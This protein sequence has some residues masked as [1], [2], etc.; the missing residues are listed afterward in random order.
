V[1]QTIPRSA[2]H[3]ARAAAYQAWPRLALP[4]VGCRSPLLALLKSGAMSRQNARN[5]AIVRV[6]GAIVLPVALSGANRAAAS[7]LTLAG[8]LRL[9]I[10]SPRGTIRAGRYSA[11]KRGVI[12]PSMV[13]SAGEHYVL[14][15]LHMLGM[16]AALAPRNAP[17]VDILV[18]HADET[19]A[20]SLQVKT[21]R[22]G[23]DKGWHMSEKHERIENSRLFYAFVDLEPSAPTV[24]IVPSAIVAE[25]VRKSHKAWLATPG[26]KGQAH[27]DHDMRRIIPNYPYAVESYP[28]GWLDKYLNQWDQL[29]RSVP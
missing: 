6:D 1:A 2:G 14:Y 28:D 21:R 12:E 17:T 13:G 16:M 26:R 15:Q 22:S 5:A 27:N 7:R 23:A 3:R 11:M 25:A 20:A 19:I 9:W 10:G 4:A 18:L 24:F 29:R 8:L